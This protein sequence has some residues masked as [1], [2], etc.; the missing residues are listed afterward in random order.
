MKPILHSSSISLLNK[1]PGLAHGF[2]PRAYEREDGTT[3]ELNFSSGSPSSRSHLQ[4]FLRSI[5]IH[6]DEVFK[7]RQV[8]GDDVYE[9][10]DASTSSAQ[11]VDVPADAIITR[12]VDRPIG[13]LTA[14]CIPVVVYDFR[15]RV[16][17]VI[18]AGRKGTAKNIVSKTIQAMQKLYGSEPQDIVAGMG[19]GIGPC[20]YEVDAD[21][22]EP[23]KRSYPGWTGFAKPFPSGKFMLD[24]FSANAEDAKMAGIRPENISQTGLCTSCHVARFFSY[25]R[26]ATAGRMLT[27][28]MLTSD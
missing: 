10:K 2:S 3:T 11:V 22:I 4:L 18:H 12:L 8:H 16:A 28:A 24:L 1:Q 26:E 13:I 25:R 15:A 20:C 23:F 6:S 19:P 5:G 14:D 27:V 7:V 17:G 9:L 21:C